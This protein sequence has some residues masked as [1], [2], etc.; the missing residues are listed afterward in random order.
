MTRREAH[1]THD[2]VKAA[3]EMVT[4]ALVTARSGTPDEAWA[5]REEVP[6]CGTVYMVKGPLVN[7]EAT[8]ETRAHDTPGK[9][10]EDLA[11]R[12]APKPAHL[13]PTCS[14]K[15]RDCACHKPGELT[16]DDVLGVRAQA[17]RPARRE[18][19]QGAAAEAH[20]EAEDRAVT[21]ERKAILAHLQIAPLYLWHGYRI[22][23]RGETFVLW[24]FDGEAST[25]VDQGPIGDLLIAAREKGAL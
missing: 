12:R 4:G 10:I 25:C 16:V 17:S 1:L 9:A 6:R 20:S 14:H 7:G 21:A 19:E 11:E 13:C 15:W 18:A 2:H 8:Q 24:H 23:A 5:W 3:V 22:E